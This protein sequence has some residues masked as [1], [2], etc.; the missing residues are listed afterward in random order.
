L[1]DGE[2]EGKSIASQSKNEGLQSVQKV[3]HK[4]SQSE[5][6]S[7][8]IVEAKPITQQSPNISPGLLGSQKNTVDPIT[9]YVPNIAF[10]LGVIAIIEGES[11]LKLWILGLMA[12]TWWARG[13]VERGLQGRDEKNPIEETLGF[14]LVVFFICLLSLIVCSIKSML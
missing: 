1:I 8:S 5:R 14:T 2:L 10:G 6:V 13:V 7:G 12:G 4:N 9:R 3:Q 11:S